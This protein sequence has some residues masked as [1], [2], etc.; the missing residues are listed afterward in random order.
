MSYQL[1]HKQHVIDPHPI[2]DLNLL[3]QILTFTLDTCYMCSLVN[4][5]TLSLRGF[6]LKR[7][8]HL[9]LDWDL[10]SL[11]VIL[12]Y[13]EC[14]TLLTQSGVFMKGQSTFFKE[15]KDFCVYFWVVLSYLLVGGSPFTSFTILLRMPYRSSYFYQPDHKIMVIKTNAHT[16]CTT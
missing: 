14:D 5:S 1:F 12:C 10:I 9:R 11:S 3:S 7:Q 2:I 15:R 6:K 8:Y 13:C 16:V 4:R